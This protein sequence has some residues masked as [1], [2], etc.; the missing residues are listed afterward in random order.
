[1]YTCDE[2]LRTNQKEISHFQQHGFV[3]TNSLICIRAMDNYEQVN[4]FKFSISRSEITYSK[5]KIN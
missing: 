2:Q 5:T 1:L 4:R 3:N